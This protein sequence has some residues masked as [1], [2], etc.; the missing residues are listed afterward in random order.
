M[1]PLPPSD[2]HTYCLTCVDRFSRWPEVFPMPDMKAETCVETLLQGWIE[3]FGVPD[4]I[5]TDRGSQFE[6]ELFQAFTQFLGSQRIR[7]I[8]Y[9]PA[10]NGMGE[11]FHRQLKD[12]VRCYCLSAPR[13]T[14]ILPMVILGYAIRGSL[15]EDLSVSPAELPYGEPL[16]LPD[17]FF[18]SCETSPSI[19]ELI[20]RLRTKIQSL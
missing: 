5:T 17:E 11:R 1:G 6:F 18:R 20:G 8:S 19:P 7:T 4:I 2:G 15:K 13:W 10:S 14:S 3:R 9:H 16:R 12:A